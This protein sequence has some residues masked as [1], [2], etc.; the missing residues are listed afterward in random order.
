MAYPFREI[1]MTGRY[2]DE[3]GKKQKNVKRIFNELMCQIMIRKS[4]CFICYRVATSLNPFKIDSC[5]H[6]A[7]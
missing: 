7:T 1:G 5:H 2:E 6:D 3:G 4:L